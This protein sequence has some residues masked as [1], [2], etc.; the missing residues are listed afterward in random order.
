MSLRQVLREVVESGEIQI[1]PEYEKKKYFHWIDNLRDWCVSRQIWWGHQIP[2]WYRGAEDIY[3]GHRQPDGDGWRQDDDTLDTWFSSALWT[4]STLA[5]SEL[6]R[7]GNLDLR[8]VL[9]RSPDFQKFHPTSVMETGYDILFFWVTRMILMTTYFV[10]QVPFRTVYLHGLILDENG[11]KMSKSHPETCIDPLDVIE[12]DGADTLRLALIAGSSAGRDT[13]LGKEHIQSCK[14]LTNKLWNAAKLVQILT[15]NSSVGGSSPEAE[16]D[17]SHP[18]NRWM[19]AL[20]ARLAAETD[21]R[22]ARYEFSDAL[23]NLRAKFWDD[24]CDFYLEAAKIEDLKKL[25][26]TARV[27]NESFGCFLRLFHPFAPFITEAIW[28]NLNKSGLLLQDEF[29]TFTEAEDK[30]S[31]TADATEAVI[32][33]INA[34]RSTRALLQIDLKV[35]PDIFVQTKKYDS[36][37]ETCA[38]V[39]RQLARVEKIS[40]EGVVEFGNFEQD[41]TAFYDQTFCVIFDLPDAYLRAERERVLKQ[42]AEAKAYLLKLENRLQGENFLAKASAEII[43]ATRSDAEKTK[44]IIADF[45][46]RLEFLD[47]KQ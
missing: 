45:E 2:V 9:R 15:E 7:D 13:R 34:V 5:D 39:I 29:L 42:T 11:E 41:L 26:E 19:L 47:K 30:P 6:V 10:E 35:K 37:F 16:S 33:L 23:E 25:P 46:R 36:V 8:E 3:V 17:V 32:R 12:R 43:E 24:F 21:E 31:E 22:L 40:I 28:Q 4:W 20:V 18:V 27:L 38:P 1:L 14:R 44:T